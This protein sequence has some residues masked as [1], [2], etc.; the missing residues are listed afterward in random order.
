MKIKS[1]YHTIVKWSKYKPRSQGPTQCRNCTMYGHGTQNCHRRPTCTL[2]ASNDHNQSS[3]PIKNLAMESSP[4]YKCSYC[5]NKNIQP[6]NHRAS[7]PDCPA[8]Q[9]YIKTRKTAAEQQQKSKLARNNDNKDQNRRNFIP[10][11]E[12][13][14]LTRTYSS[15]TSGGKRNEIGNNS[16][17]PNEDLFTSAKL[18]GIFKNAVQQIKNCRT[19]L[20]QIQVIA[21]LINYVI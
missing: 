16:S 12:P 1:I 6:T 18:F 9:E 8:R 14:P 2:C 19:K 4:V 11:P 17:S 3:C 13:P 10:A 15:V 21:E 20:D 7:D 5:A